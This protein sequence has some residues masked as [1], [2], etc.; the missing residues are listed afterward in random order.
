[1]FL[2]L[3]FQKQIISSVVVILNDSAKYQYPQT[4]SI[5]VIGCGNFKKLKLQVNKKRENIFHAI[6]LKHISSDMIQFWYK[7]GLHTH[8][9][10]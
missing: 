3:K 9:Y 8:F 2:Q 10:I 7:H 4:P 6:T 5:M 1:M